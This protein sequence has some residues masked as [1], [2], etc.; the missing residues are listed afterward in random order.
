MT[1]YELR[2]TASLLLI[3]RQGKLR[4]NHFGILPDLGLGAQIMQLVGDNA[5]TNGLGSSQ[6]T[7]NSAGCSD[8]GRVIDQGND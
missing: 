7:E 6:A 8:D 3:D 4:N 1:A 2:G 5:E